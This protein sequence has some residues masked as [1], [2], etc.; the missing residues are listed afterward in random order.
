MSIFQ[1]W[2][3]S[4]FTRFNQSMFFVN[5]KRNRKNL[6]RKDRFET[7]QGSSTTDYIQY[8]I[9]IQNSKSNYPL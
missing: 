3:C 4:C 5:Y 6:F 8:L 1:F 7:E 2:V 9:F